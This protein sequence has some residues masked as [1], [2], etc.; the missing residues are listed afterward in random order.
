MDIWYPGG[1]LI[2][3]RLASMSWRS[4]SVSKGLLESMVSGK[5]S[6]RSAMRLA[7][8]AKRWCMGST[9]VQA[10]G[11]KYGKRWNLTT[12]CQFRVQ[13][14][15]SL[16]DMLQPSTVQQ[17]RR[18]PASF[19]VPKCLDRSSKS[20]F[21]WDCLLVRGAACCICGG[22]NMSEC[23]WT[24]RRFLQQE[25]RRQQSGEQHGFWH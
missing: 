24:R 4:L 11:S 3:C 23:P 8:P 18:Y 2:F 5:R 19:V 20:P 12:V 25:Y 10:T 16:P 7:V 14:L 6:Q 22:R 1:S 21:V 15:A 17:L 13:W 9:M